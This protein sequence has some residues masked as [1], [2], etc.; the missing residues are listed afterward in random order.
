MHASMI[1]TGYTKVVNCI[2]ICQMNIHR[3]WQKSIETKNLNVERIMKDT[4]SK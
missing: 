3:D 4:V 2:L 1:C